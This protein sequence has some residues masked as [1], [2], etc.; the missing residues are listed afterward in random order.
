M[1][2]LG[3]SKASAQAGPRTKAASGIFS[4]P[5]CNWCPLQ[6]YSL[7]PSAIGARY[8]YIPSLLLPSALVG[9]AARTRPPTAR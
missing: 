8:G 7:S 6:V 2:R 3:G 1:R 5:S 4:L 9:H